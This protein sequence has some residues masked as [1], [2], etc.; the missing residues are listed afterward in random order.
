ML[1]RL[2]NCDALL[3]D[4]L[5]KSSDEARSSTAN[6]ARAQPTLTAMSHLLNV[7]E[8]PA[9]RSLLADYQAASSAKN[10]PVWGQEL[11][12]CPNNSIHVFTE[13][14]KRMKFFPVL[15]VGLLLLGSCAK[16]DDPNRD[17]PEFEMEWPGEIANGLP[18]SQLG[19]YLNFKLNTR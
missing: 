12:N 7:T 6:Y 18:Y 5:F 14:F 8:T 16:N 13:I 1:V 11:S 19:P 4:W 17:K 3:P 2:R 10:I 15:V 9:N